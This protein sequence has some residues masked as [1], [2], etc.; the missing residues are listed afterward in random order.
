MD[1]A[2]LRLNGP[3]CRPHCSHLC[4]LQPPQLHQVLP[5]NPLQCFVLGHDLLVGLP[6]IPQDLKPLPHTFVRLLCQLYVELCGLDFRWRLHHPF[7]QVLEAQVSGL[8]LGAELVDIVLVSLLLCLL[9]LLCSMH[10]VRLPSVIQDL[11]LDFCNTLPQALLLL[12]QLLPFV[13]VARL[14]IRRTQLGDLLCDVIRPLL[15]LERLG[16]LL[17]GLPHAALLLRVRH[18]RALLGVGT[19]AQIKVHEPV[20][21]LGLESLL[22]VRCLLLLLVE[23]YLHRPDLGLKGAQ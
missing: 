10:D 7:L 4:R 23:G 14:F 13:D 2:V 1:D 19:P 17:L 9:Q 16:L 3:R 15:Q 21:P 11:L 8:Q 6:I 22:W 5:F 18:L 20:P 12:D